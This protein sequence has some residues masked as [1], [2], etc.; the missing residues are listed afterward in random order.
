MSSAVSCVVIL[1]CPGQPQVPTPSTR[2]VSATRAAQW[3]HRSR[4][5]SLSTP[6]P[7]D[8]FRRPDKHRAVSPYV[9]LPAMMSLRQLR[10]CLLHTAWHTLRR[11]NYIS[12]ML[13]SA[14][15]V[16]MRTSFGAPGTGASAV[17]T[18]GPDGVQT[19]QGASASSSAPAAT[20]PS[21]SAA[22]AAPSGGTFHRFVNK[23]QE[24]LDLSWGD[25]HYDNHHG[26]VQPGKSMVVG[27]C[28]PDLR[29]CPKKLAHVARV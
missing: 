25:D 26:T 27:E 9:T 24:P 18:I 7:R 20:Q 2:G 28:Y 5:R 10:V 29:V 16:K 6:K 15:T 19:D 17:V 1:P 11:T 21:T 3:W 4:V 14:Q 8:S 22:S 12:H 13:P 23:T